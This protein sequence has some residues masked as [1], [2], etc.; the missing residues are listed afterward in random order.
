MATV[1]AM[2]DEWDV[3]TL[4]FRAAMARV[5]RARMPAERN[6]IYGSFPI[7][8]PAEQPSVCTTSTNLRAQ[9]MRRGKK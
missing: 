9:R 6:R 7:C 5:M 4:V 1:N 3:E 8:P 2:R